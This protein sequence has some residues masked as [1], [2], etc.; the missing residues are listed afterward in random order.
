MTCG[1]RVLP[2]SDYLTLF[3]TLQS[4]VN[5]VNNISIK[6]ITFMKNIFYCSE[7]IA[8]KNIDRKINTVL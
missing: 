8:S 4:T 7:F 2:A 1:E 6:T 5:G 3:Y